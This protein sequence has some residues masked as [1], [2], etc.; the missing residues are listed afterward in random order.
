VVIFVAF[1]SE[2]LKHLR[3]ERK[4]TQKEI[5]RLFKVTERGYQNYEIGKSYPNYRS[6]VALADYFDVSLDYLCGRS[7]EPERR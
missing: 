7:D 4:I 2:R 5:A 6:L 3:T 1:F